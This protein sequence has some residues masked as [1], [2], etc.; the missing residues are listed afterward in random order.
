MALAVE[1]RTLRELIVSVGPP[2]KAPQLGQ[3]AHAQLNEV[4]LGG[5]RQVGQAGNI[6]LLPHLRAT[7]V[8]VIAPLAA[9]VEVPQ[10]LAG[11]LLQEANK[12]VCQ[13]LLQVGPDCRQV[14]PL[15]GGMTA[16]P[17]G[18]LVEVHAGVLD[19]G[20]FDQGGQFERVEEHL[21]PVGDLHLLGPLDLDHAEKARPAVPLDL[22]QVGVVVAEIDEARVD[23]ER[24]V[25]PQRWPQVG[26]VDDASGLK[27]PQQLDSP[28]GGK[29]SLGQRLLA[30]GDRHPA[31]E[32]AVHHLFFPGR[33]AVHHRTH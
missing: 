31:R 15:R 22:Q 32:E 28:A 25:E 7:V 4:P 2:E 8:G 13:K 20:L 19:A 11:L 33:P 30:R 29:P 26:L 3:V 14:E 9:V 6:L 1:G 12:I 27:V 23:P 17:D 10:R 21:N 18:P 5:R 24:G 16:E